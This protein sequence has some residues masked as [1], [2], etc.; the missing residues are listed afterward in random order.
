MIRAVISE[1]DE[2]ASRVRE[3][4]DD[5]DSWRDQCS[6]RVADWAAEHERVRELQGALQGFYRNSNRHD[7]PADIYDAATAALKTS[8][9]H[10]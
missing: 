10:P 7:W 8:K 3:L 6:Q 4:T 5:R 1:R 9:E 2:L